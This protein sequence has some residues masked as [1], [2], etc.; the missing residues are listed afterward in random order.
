MENDRRNAIHCNALNWESHYRADREI[1]GPRPWPV[2][3]SRWLTLKVSHLLFVCVCVCLLPP[4]PNHFYFRPRNRFARRSTKNLPP[5][6]LVLFC[7]FIVCGRRFG[8]RRRRRPTLWVSSILSLHFET[9]PRVN[10]KL[11]ALPFF[12]SKSELHVF[13]FASKGFFFTNFWLGSLIMFGLR[14]LLGLIGYFFKVKKQKKING[15]DWFIASSWG[16]GGYLFGVGVRTRRWP[17][18][19]GPTLCRLFC[20]VAAFFF[21]IYGT[22]LVVRRVA[23][24]SHSRRERKRVERREKPKKKE[25]WRKI[26][27]ATTTTTTTGE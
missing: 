9:M 21:G 16:S 25:P 20:F 17:C 4:P 1:G 11:V 14:P 6:L 22:R 26:T 19:S 8:Q 12:F 2:I 3:V 5:A 18:G 10:Q 13:S 15:F 7:F 24:S 23:R 27:T